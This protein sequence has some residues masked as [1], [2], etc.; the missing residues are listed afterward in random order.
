MCYCFIL[1]VCYK[2][3][4]SLDMD[5]KLSTLPEKENGK[6]LSIDGNPDVE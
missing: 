3:E 2:N 6:L 1:Y 5:D 4:V